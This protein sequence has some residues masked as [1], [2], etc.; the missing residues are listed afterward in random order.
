MATVQRLEMSGLAAMIERSPS[1]FRVVFPDLSQAEAR[2]VTLK[3]D[4]LG[5]REYTVTII[6]RQL[7]RISIHGGA[8]TMRHLDHG[9]GA[10][11]PLSSCIGALP[12]SWAAT[13]CSAWPILR[14]PIHCRCSASTMWA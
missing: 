6:R 1:R 13:S 8:S 14:Q 12:G 3:L 9:F 11:R 7:S 2:I 4:G 5:Y 10:G